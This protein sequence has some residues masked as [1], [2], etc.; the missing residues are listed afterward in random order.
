MKSLDSFIKH[1]EEEVA[2]HSI[3]VWGAQGQTG[4]TITEAWIRKRETSETNANRDHVVREVKG[5]R[6][7]ILYGKTVV[8]AV[9]VDDLTLI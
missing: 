7:V 2:N 1:L 4:A 5:D 8:A 3:Y 6:A 9:N